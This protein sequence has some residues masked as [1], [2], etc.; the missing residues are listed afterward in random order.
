MCQFPDQFLYRF[1][2]LTV[3]GRIGGAPDYGQVHM[4]FV[5]YQVFRQRDFVLPVGFPNS[6]SKKISHHGLLE[7]SFGHGYKNSCRRQ[8][9]ASPGNRVQRPETA[10]THMIA[11]GEQVIDWLDAAKSFTFCERGVTCCLC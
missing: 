5:F 2:Y 1:F 8:V 10:Q 11:C 4:L 6:S 7:I 3:I 9:S